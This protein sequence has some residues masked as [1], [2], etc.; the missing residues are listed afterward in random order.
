[1]G[2]AVESFSHTEPRGL[3]ASQSRPADIFTT[4]AVPGRGGVLDACRLLCA[5][6][7]RG[8]A[9]QAPFDRKLSNYRDEISELRHQCI[10]YRPLSFGQRTGDHTLLSLGH[11]STQQTSH[12]AAMASRCRR[13]R[14]SADGNMK[15]RLLFFAGGQP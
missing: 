5:A 1:M 10:Y 8:D 6:A 12:P 11:C 13:N 4:A 2:S 9:P 14:S 7:A 15:S 3:T